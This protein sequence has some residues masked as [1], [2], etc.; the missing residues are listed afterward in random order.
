[1][2]ADPHQRAAALAELFTKVEPSLW[3]D[4][5]ESGG[6]A[7]GSGERERHEWRCLAL[8]ACVRGLVAAGGFNIETV[9]AVDHLHSL[10]GE[11]WTR[12]ER[13]TLADRYSEYGRIGQELEAAGAHQVTQKLGEA[14]AAHI[15]ES[16]PSGVLAELLGTLH[17]SLVEGAAA[18]VREGAR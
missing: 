12:E 8:Y 17:D 2:L 6:L 9:A 7:D 18:A 4:F 14:C 5:V 3:R 13:A 11:P 15:T 1:M 10:I 16:T